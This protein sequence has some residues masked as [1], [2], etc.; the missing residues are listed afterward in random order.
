MNRKPDFT[1]LERRLA[2]FAVPNLMKIIV[3]GQAAV[4]LL[5]WLWPVSLGGGSLVSL[6]ALTRAG[7]FR[8]QIWR[9]VTFLFVPT[10]SSPIFLL[11]SLYFYWF[12]GTRLEAY[13]GKVR[14]CLFYLIGALGAVLAALITGYAGNTYLNLSIFF[15]YASVWPEEQV[16]LFMIVPVRMKYLALL[17]AA[18]YLISFI[19]GGA[20]ARVTILLCLANVALFV[21]GNWLSLLKKDMRYWK[22]RRNFRNTMWKR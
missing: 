3:F 5:T 1:D 10:S 11:I 20:A 16:L 13:W 21:G 18:L 6:L 17:D 2:P 9:L 8:G 7:L 4:Y 12:I 15:A 19:R 14:F 22:T